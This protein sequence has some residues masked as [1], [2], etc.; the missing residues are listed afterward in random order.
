MYHQRYYLLYNTV[1]LPES[2][3]AVDEHNLLSDL[4]AVATNISN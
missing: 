1:S 3:A 2:F 4:L